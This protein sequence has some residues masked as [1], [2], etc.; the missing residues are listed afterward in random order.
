MKR[1]L[2][3]SLLALATAAASAQTFDANE[4][5]ERTPTPKSLV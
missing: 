1:I 2:F 3:A 4:V 5:R